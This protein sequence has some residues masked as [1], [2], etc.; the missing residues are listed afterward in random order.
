MKVCV[1]GAGLSGLIT[2]RYLLDKAEY[3]DI[4]AY[5]QAGDIGGTWVYTDR[6]GTDEKGMPL[7]SSMYRDLR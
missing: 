3:F 4:T 6:V 5:E 2:L 7:L 1:V